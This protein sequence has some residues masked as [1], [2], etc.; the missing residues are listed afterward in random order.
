M[1]YTDTRLQV[2][3]IE[4]IGDGRVTSQGTRVRLNNGMYLGDVQDL[5]LNANH[6]DAWTVDVTVRAHITSQQVL[7]LFGKIDNETT[8][9]QAETTDI[10]GTETNQG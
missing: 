9:A 4:V 6:G 2:A 1:K 8:A 3:S 10:E 7:E 5:S